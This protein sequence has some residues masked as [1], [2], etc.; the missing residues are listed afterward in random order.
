MFGVFGWYLSVFHLQE[1]NRQM[2]DTYGKKI[3]QV[4]SK[5]VVM[6]PS[7]GQK[8]DFLPQEGGGGQ[9]GLR[10]LIRNPECP[11]GIVLGNLRE[12]S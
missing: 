1:P 9:T 5:T 11:R 10:P 4:P 2:Q 6:A 7:Y 8:T 3:H 12:T